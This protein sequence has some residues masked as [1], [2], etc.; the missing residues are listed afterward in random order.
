MALKLTLKPG[1]KFVI[2][3]AVLANGD[4]RN[5]IV[6]HNKASIL[7]E[8]D[9]MQVDD[10]DTPVKRIY[11][12]I[13]SMYLDERARPTFYEEFALRMSEFMSVISND[14]AKA[15]CLAISKQVMDRRYYSA[16]MHCKK[17]LQFERERLDYEPT[18]VPA[19]AAGD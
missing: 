8:K 3:G 4:R 10:V 15:T 6:V 5:S 19:S 9:V 2:N 11:F 12:A 1:E 17:L 14:F 16:L 7:R 13:M 18:S